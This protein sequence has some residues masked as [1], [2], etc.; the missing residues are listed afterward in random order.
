MCVC[1][2]VCVC[3]C[4]P[5]HFSCKICIPVY[6][7]LSQNELERIELELHTAHAYIHFISVDVIDVLLGYQL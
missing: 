5:L 7:S 4:M 1:V 2:C 3:A 6:S